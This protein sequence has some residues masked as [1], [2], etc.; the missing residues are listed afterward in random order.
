MAG[1]FR[2]L[3]DIALADAAFEVSADSPSELCALAGRAVIESLANPDTVGTRWRRNMSRQHDSLAGL[4]FDWLSDIVYW[5]D[6]A[7][8]VY[9]DLTAT[10]VEDAAGWRLTGTLIGDAI[11]PQRQELRADVKAVTKHLYTVEQLADRTW[12]A[13]VVLDL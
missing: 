12:R 6:A 9:H 5:K 11:D 13:R 1:S 3:E 8:V 2:F 7:A 10:V 4:L